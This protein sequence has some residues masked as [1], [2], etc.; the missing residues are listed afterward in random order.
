MSTLTERILLFCFHYEP[1][2]GKYVLAAKTAMRVSGIV[3]TLI[4]GLFVGAL[5]RRERRR[6]ATG[7]VISQGASG[8]A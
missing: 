7:R 5:F 2:I 3:S 8:A 1:S 4:L 6:A